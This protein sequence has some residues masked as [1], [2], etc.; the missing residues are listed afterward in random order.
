MN[1]QAIIRRKIQLKGQ[2]LELIAA[3]HRVIIYKIKAQRKDLIY[4]LYWD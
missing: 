2:H 3:E 1:E 4:K